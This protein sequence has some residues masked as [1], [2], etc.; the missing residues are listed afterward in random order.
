MGYH[1]H[2]LA[3]IAAVR[4]GLTYGLNE[5]VLA[6]L[7]IDKLYFPHS[8][9]GVVVVGNLFNFIGATSIVLAAP[10]H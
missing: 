6:S 10:A 1:G 5:Q 7:S 3:V 4:W 9:C 2:I 8:L